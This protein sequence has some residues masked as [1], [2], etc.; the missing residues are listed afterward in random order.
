M[1][2]SSIFLTGQKFSGSQH[3]RVPLI[4]QEE[5]NLKGIYDQQM[6]NNRA[7]V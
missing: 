7:L 6:P 5:W 4:T 2:K 3:H 1:T